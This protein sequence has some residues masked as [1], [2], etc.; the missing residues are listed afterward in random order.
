MLDDQESRAQEIITRLHTQENYIIYSQE[1]YNI[2]SQ[3][4]WHPNQ[5]HNLSFSYSHYECLLIHQQYNWHSCLSGT[6]GLCNTLT[7]NIELSVSRV[8]K[9]LLPST[10]PINSPFTRHSS[11]ATSSRGLRHLL[12]DKLTIC[13]NIQYNL[14]VTKLLGSGRIICYREFFFCTRLVWLR[15]L[16]WVFL[17]LH[18]RCLD[19]DLLFD[20]EVT[21]TH[22]G[23]GIRTRRLQT[24][25]QKSTIRLLPIFK[26]LCSY[27]R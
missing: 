1:N 11:P 8:G 5:L 19:R 4:V 24:E 14:Q 23:S 25:R 16:Q 13:I 26:E 10:I 27:L 2:S 3:L 7:Y 15:A 12:V 17:W 6:L 20:S 21:N 18:G 22:A 9:I